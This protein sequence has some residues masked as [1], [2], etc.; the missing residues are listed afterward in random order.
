MSLQG[1]CWLHRSPGLLSSTA[2]FISPRG[3][4]GRALEAPTEPGKP[5]G[6][7]CRA[8]LRGK[9]TL[10]GLGQGW[11][12]SG[13]TEGPVGLEEEEGKRGSLPPTKWF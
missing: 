3:A 2:P 6:D 5:A 9:D 12:G 1:S 11:E 8:H 10:E 4:H 13:D 7:A